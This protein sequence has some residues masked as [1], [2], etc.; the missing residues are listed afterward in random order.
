MSIFQKGVMPST[1]GNSGKR[2][3]SRDAFLGAASMAPGIFDPLNY[4]WQLGSRVL[5]GQKATTAFL[6]VSFFLSAKH[7]NR[8]H[9]P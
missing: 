5:E 4:F 8:T 3:K 2:G 1:S 7:T 9:E 6:T